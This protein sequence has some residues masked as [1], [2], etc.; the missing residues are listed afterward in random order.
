M[1]QGDSPAPLSPDTT[2]D[3]RRVEGGGNA[4][5]HL[6]EEVPVAVVYNAV[7]YAVML[8]TPLDLE[9]FA[10]GFSV[11][12]RIVDRADAIQAVETRS[13]P[14]GVDL[15]IRIDEHSFERLGL[16]E[17]RRNLAGR[18]GCGICGLDNAEAFFEPL[19]RVAQNIAVLDPQAAR[20]AVDSFPERQTL[21]LLTHSVHGAA[22]VDWSG[23][24][25]T[26]REDIGR[27]NALDKLLGAQARAG[28]DMTAGFALVSSRCSYELVEKA[29]RFGVTALMSL[30]AP[31][32]F[33][34]R[35]A[36]EA[37]LALY[38]WSKEGLIGVI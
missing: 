37:N 3:I 6:A 21:N 30:S 38:S 7:N 34:V 26:V 22:W 25:E 24:I 16:R 29:A 8:A 9:D 1:S 18:T 5:W 2:V 27:H 4:T 35:R 36:R 13:R 23:T 20:R 14:Q 11:S 10:V 28:G 17:G 33:A 15:M 32:A 31:T 19:P 12:E